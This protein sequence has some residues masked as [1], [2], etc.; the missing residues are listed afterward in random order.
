ML[1]S[2]YIVTG[3]VVMERFNVILISELEDRDSVKMTE[4]SLT[5]LAKRHSRNFKS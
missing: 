3:K 5:G 4:L 1:C 2:L